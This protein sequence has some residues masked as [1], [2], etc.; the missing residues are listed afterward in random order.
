MALELNQT[1]Q[2]GNCIVAAK[3][4]IDLYSSPQL[5]EAILKA[6][7]AKTRK[8]GIDL[9]DVGY[10]DSSGVAT[11]VEGLQA[12]G[13]ADSFALVAPS[14]PVLKVLQLSRLDSVFPIVEQL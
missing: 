2:D 9:R 5:R 11:L 10:M 14:Q 6:C 7:K 4:E 12:A 1:E 8:V 13:G 3:G